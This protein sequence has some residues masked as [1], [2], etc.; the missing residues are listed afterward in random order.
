MLTFVNSV[1]FLILMALGLVVLGIQIWAFSDCLRTAPSD[2]DRVYKR[3]KSFWLA[4]TGG[5][6]FFGILYVLPSLLVLSTPPLGMSLILTL[7]GVVA[8]GTYLADVR[9]MLLE[10]RGRGKGQQ[11]RG[12]SW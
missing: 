11:N 1:S 6:M 3:S 9:P 10:V 7:G 5:S 2:F 12:S 8:A 4:L